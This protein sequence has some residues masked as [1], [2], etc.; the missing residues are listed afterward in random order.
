MSDI[1]VV[2]LS[3]TAESLGIDSENL[4]FSKL[5]NDYSADFPNLI[6]RTNFNRRRRRLNGFIA[7]VSKSIANQI[8]PSKSAYI[9]DSIP[10]P[11]CRNVRIYLSRV[12]KENPEVRPARSFHASYKAYYYGFKL[13]L[14]INRLGVP[15][16]VT[17][18]SANMHGS[19]YLA[20]IGDLKLTECEPG[21][22]YG[23]SQPRAPD[24]PF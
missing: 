6:D 17:L 7:L 18:S 9:L 14:V 19:R 5:K 24:E 23:L 16:S 12:C 8:D 1:E 20:H 10:L 13:Q 4:L 15:Y 11:I 2:A 21:C 3:I 22:G